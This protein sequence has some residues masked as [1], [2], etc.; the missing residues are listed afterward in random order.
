LLSALL[1]QR[2]VITDIIVITTLTAT[3][4]NGSGVG[5]APA[6]KASGAVLFLRPNRRFRATLEDTQSTRLLHPA[7]AQFDAYST[8]SRE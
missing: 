8:L 6:A 7:N 3:L 2:A 1:S 5:T 4:K